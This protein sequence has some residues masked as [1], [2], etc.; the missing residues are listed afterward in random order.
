MARPVVALITDFGTRDPYVA[1]MKGVVLS[2]CPDV[3]LVDLTHDIPPHDVR[4]GA[5]ALAGCYAYY[6]AGTIF[7][8]VVDPGVGSARRGVAVDVGDYRLVGPDNG[9]LGAVCDERPPRKIVELTDR[10][11]QRPTVSRT[12]EGRDRF[13]PAAAW[14]AK[15]TAVTA[16][17]RAVH[18]LTRLAWPVPAVTGDGITGE[19]VSVDRFGNL[20]SN[21]ARP[22]VDALLRD[23][24]VEI[25]LGVHEIPRLVATYA[26][27]AAGEVCALFGSTDHLEIAVNG[28]SAAGHFAAAAGTPVTVRRR[29]G[30]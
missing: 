29:A 17:G 1:A 15:G 10:K 20:I 27:A 5:R 8:A 30:V 19:V 24:A 26:E 18:D 22:A 11:F 9:V 23:G 2:I 21:V 12:F 14:L 25:R 6:P 4:A 3:T 13:A 28:A 16:L 7:V